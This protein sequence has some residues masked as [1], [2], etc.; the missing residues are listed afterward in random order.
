MLGADGQPISDTAI[1]TVETDEADERGTAN[2]Q[3]QSVSAPAV[4]QGDTATISAAVRNTGNASGTQNVSYTLEGENVTTG[5][6]AVDIVFVLDQS[7]SMA[8]DNAVVRRELRNFTTQLE[9]ENVDVQYAVVSMERPSSVVQNFTSDVGTT[10]SAIE[11]VLQAGGGTE[12]NFEALALAVSL[13]DTSGR[14]NAQSVII[15]VTGEGSNVAQPSQT[16]LSAEFNRTNTTYIAVTPAANQSTMKDYPPS[17]QKRPLAN[18]TESGTWFNLVE[19]DFGDRFTTQIAQT[20]V[21]VS[22]RNQRRLQL[23]AGASETVTFQVNTTDL[24]RRPTR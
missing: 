16:D 20:V 5:A 14:P 6:S 2:F 23:D 3:I 15:D 18:M 13:F 12:D 19:G 9:S 8:D 11:Q 10:R 21:D 1:V 22:R 17:V 24:P 7:G 4:S